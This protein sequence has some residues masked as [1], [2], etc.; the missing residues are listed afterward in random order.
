MNF[1]LLKR[2][3]CLVLI[4]SVISV[5]FSASIGVSASQ[6]SDIRNE[7]SNLEEESK[8]IEAEIAKLKKDK[9]EQASIKA[10]LDKKIAVTQKEINAYNSKITQLKNE[11]A[12]SE[13]KIADKNAEIVETK[14]KFKRR[15]RSMY[16]SNSTNYVQLLLS[17]ESFADFLTLTELTQSMSAQDKIVINKIVEVIAEIQ[18][19]IE[20]NKKRQEEQ[21]AAKAVLDKKKA[22]LDSEVAEVNGIIANINADASKLNSDNASIE[23]QIKQKEDELYELLNGVNLYDGAFDGYLLWPVPGYTYVS[24][25]WDSNDPVHQGNHAGIDIAGGSISGKKVVAA[26]TGV[27][28][29]IDNYCTHNYRKNYSCGCGGGYGNNIRVDHGKYGDYYYRTIYAHLTNVDSS[30]YV[31]KSVSRGTTVGYVGCTGW[32]TGPHLHFGVARNSKENSAYN[33]WVNPYIFKFVYK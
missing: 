25:G 3:L 33:S 22:E 17:A 6:E 5:V 28:S 4:F 1:K 31:G 12:A 16:L 11:I 20:N 27:V 15:V 29:R 30:M 23:K 32:S 21:A 24:A 2:V 13:E 10:A 9:A 8:K 7:I 18:V 14:E 19:E 26:A